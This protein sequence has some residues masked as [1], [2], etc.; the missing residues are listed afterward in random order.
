MLQ[1]R[2][3]RRAA[4]CRG[5]RRRRSRSRR[6]TPRP[7]A[8]LRRGRGRGSDRSGWRTSGPGTSRQLR[9]RPR[10]AAAARRASSSGSGPSASP[11]SPTTRSPWS[12][13]DPQREE[14]GRL[15][16]EHDVA[17]HG[18]QRQHQVERARAPGGDQH[19]RRR[20]DRRRPRCDARRRPPDRHRARGRSVRQ[21]LPT[22]G[23]QHVA[24]AS[25]TTSRGK[26]DG[27]GWPHVRSITPSV[28]P[29]CTSGSA[30][31]DRRPPRRAGPLP[32]FATRHRDSRRS[33]QRD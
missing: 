29:Y 25:A 19:A 12:R 30:S 16:D 5:T 17:R 3:R 24:D 18:E 6:A 28:W 7:R 11:A 20:H 27:S 23:G 21:R 1:H 13:E 4:R 31:W 8:V 22:L 33:S 32:T 10:V 9:P 14:V 15:L 26:C 2:G